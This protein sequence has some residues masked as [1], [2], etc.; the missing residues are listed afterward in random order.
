MAL[1][2]TAGQTVED[3]WSTID[4]EAPLP[5]GPAL[6]TLARLERE[7]D[8]LAGRNSPLGVVAPSNMKPEASLAPFL[9][10]L[11]LVAIEFPVFKDGRGFTIARAL[12]ERFGYQGE[13]RAVGHILPD[14]YVHLRRCGVTTVEIPDG[15]ES[16][17]R[18]ALSFYDIAY[19][20]AIT[21]DRPLSLLRRRLADIHGR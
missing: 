16:R 2:D 10:R 11:S 6:V 12:R 4:D 8:A 20:P 5:E 7:G 14:Q 17:W 3:I 15:T 19:Q 18:E 9:D 21:D 1:L 13:I